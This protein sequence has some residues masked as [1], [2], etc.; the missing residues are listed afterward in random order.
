[1]QLLLCQSPSSL[2]FHLLQPIPWQPLAQH[3]ASN[4]PPWTHDSGVLG[5]VQWL[6]APFLRLPSGSSAVFSVYVAALWTTSHSHSW[7][8]GTMLG[9]LWCLLGCWVWS[10]DM[11]RT[12]WWHELNCA[13][14]PH[15]GAA[16]ITSPLQQVSVWPFQKGYL[17][18]WQSETASIH[19]LIPKC[20]Q[21]LRLRLG[22]D[23][24]LS[25]VCVVGSAQGPWKNG[26]VFEYILCTFFSYF[27]T[28]PWYL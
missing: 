3:R 14:K 2:V 18:E 22:R 17:L 16:M 11:K 7:H 4:C 20:G 8:Q 24:C 25:R 9:P 19:W 27:K 23:C 6:M 13:C 1:M 10:H 5:D 12:F 15:L 21:H 28:S 26:A